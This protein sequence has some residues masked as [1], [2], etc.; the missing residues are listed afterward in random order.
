MLNTRKYFMCS[1]TFI[2]LTVVYDLH[3]PVS[4]ISV[5]QVSASSLKL[6][7]TLDLRSRPHLDSESHLWSEGLQCSETLCKQ[8]VTLEHNRIKQPYEKSAVVY[9]W[10][11][12]KQT[13]RLSSFIFFSPW[14]TG[15]LLKNLYAKLCWQRNIRVHSLTWRRQLEV[16]SIGVHTYSLPLT[17]THTYSLNALVLKCH[18]AVA[19]LLPFDKNYPP[20]QD[21]FIPFLSEGFLHP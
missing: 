5:E 11:S 15:K 10:F 17:H 16:S 6:F 8:P 3:G 21:L 20:G 14:N 2:T 9:I 4:G 18:R 1:K 12:Q 19:E 13:L 7:V